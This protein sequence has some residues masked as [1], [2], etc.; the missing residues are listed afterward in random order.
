MIAARPAAR[1][2]PQPQPPPPLP[3]RRCVLQ[4]TPVPMRP[5]RGRPGQP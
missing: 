3:R 5:R 4:L 2:P 1:A